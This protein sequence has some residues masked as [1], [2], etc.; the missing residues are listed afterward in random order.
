M[1]C[2]HCVGIKLL[3]CSIVA[4]SLSCAGTSPCLRRPAQD[5]ATGRELTPPI[6]TTSGDIVWANDNATL[7]YTVKDHLDRP[8]KVLRHTVGQKGKDVVS[9]P[10]MCVCIGV[11]A[12]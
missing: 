7:F 11:H 10:M 4:H 5:L 8:Y 6:P 1:L 2:C 12:A 3:R 9:G